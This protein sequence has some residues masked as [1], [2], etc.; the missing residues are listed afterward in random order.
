MNAFNSFEAEILHKLYDAVG[1][2]FLDITMPIIT[3]LSDIGILWIFLAV[4]FLCFKKTRKA[5]LTMGIALIIGLLIGNITLKPLVARVR[6]YDFDPSI[7]LLIPK[8]SEFSFP[9]GHTLAS[10]GAA[11]GLFFCN[12]KWG[13]AA[14]VLAVLVG[15]S[16]LYLMVHYPL[17][18]ICGALLGTAFAYLAYK[19]S[20]YIVEKTNICT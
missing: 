15:F 11:F 7:V 17:D 14:I 18:V 2:K 1:C 9:S 3:R 12:K 13:T 19:I 16:R 10:F 5:G 20:S 6:P 8:E 4:L